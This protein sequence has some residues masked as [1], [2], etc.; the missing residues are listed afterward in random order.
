MST[1]FSPQRFEFTKRAHLAA[2]RQFY[3]AMFP[4]GVEFTDTTQ[5]A[6]DLEYAI[7]CQLAVT[8]PGDGFRAPIRFG[9]QERFREPRWMDPRFGDVTI[10]EWNLAT[11]QPSELHK[12]GAQMFVYGFYDEKR[13][14]IL[15]AA[16]VDVAFM[17]YA[18]AHGD[19]DF[20]RKPRGDQSFIGLHISA[21]RAIGAVMFERDNRAQEQAS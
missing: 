17:Q 19:I 15:Y 4:H 11:N 3:E 6:H 7:D 10:T 9:V 13:D 5:T 20:I 18:L 14:K 1:A 12:L 2:Q 21:L 16:A 8:L